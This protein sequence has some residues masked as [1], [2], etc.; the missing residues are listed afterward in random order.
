MIHSI[1]DNKIEWAL[2]GRRN[3]SE[4]MDEHDGCILGRFVHLVVESLGV[5]HMIGS[6]F[7]L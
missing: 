3:R 6:T 1:N 2:V 4:G 7:F 5:F